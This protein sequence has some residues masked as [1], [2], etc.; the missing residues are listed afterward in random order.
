M[1]RFK[2]SLGIICLSMLSN[3]SMQKACADESPVLLPGVSVAGGF[4]D[5]NSGWTDAMVPFYDDPKQI[6]YLDPQGFYAGN[7]QYT[8][9]VG[10][11]FRLLTQRAGIIGAYVFGDYNHS[12]NN[13]SFWFISPGIERLGDTLDVSVN[14]YLPVNRQRFDTSTALASQTGDTQY[15]RFSGHDEFDQLLTFFESTGVGVDGEIGYRLPFLRNNTKIYVGGYYFA[16]QNTND[17]TGITARLE[18]P[19]GNHFSFSVSDAYDNVFNNTFKLGVSLSLFGR[20]THFYDHNVETRM[21]DPIQRNRIAVEGN[22]TTSQYIAQGQVNSGTEMLIADD[23]W[24]FSPDG[25]FVTIPT[26]ETCTEEMPC[27]NRNVNSSFFGGIN[28]IDPNAKMYLAPGDYNSIN[29]SLTLFNGQ[30]LWGRTEDYKLAAAGNNRALL[31]GSLDLFGNNLVDSVRLANNPSNTQ[32]QGIFF[33]EGATN[34]LINNVLIGNTGSDPTGAFQY[35]IQTDN[36]TSFTVL[37]SEIDSFVNTAV[38]DSAP[39][40]ISNSNHTITVSNSILSANRAGTTAVR[41]SGITDTGSNNQWTITGNQISA[42]NPASLVGNMAFGIFS[43]GGNN[44][45][46]QIKNNNINISANRASAGISSTGG[47]NNVWRISS[48]NIQTLTS[49]T[50]TA[51][52]IISTNGSNNNWRVSNNTITIIDGGVNSNGIQDNLGFQDIWRLQGNSISANIALG[53]GSLNGIQ[54]NGGTS[55]IWDLI[56]NT[57]NISVSGTNAFATG[58]F[59]R[60]NNGDIWN[61]TSNQLTIHGAGSGTDAYGLDVFTT[62]NGVWNLNNNTFSI[63]ANGAN[64][65]A[66]GIDDTFST[67]NTWN[68]NNNNINV[69]ISGTNSNVFGIEN[70]NGNG[71]TWSIINN[72]IQ[73]TDFGTGDAQGIF[74]FSGNTQTW[75][76]QDNTI[77]Q[78]TTGATAAAIG[79]SDSGNQS[80]QWNVV[81]NTLNS[82]TTQSSSAA[83]GIQSR[84]STLGTWGISGNNITTSTGQLSSPSLGIVLAGNNNTYTLSDNTINALSTGN[85]AAASAYGV[86][87]GGNLN[88]VTSTGDIITV[89]ATGTGASAYG[90]SANTT[91]AATST[92]TNSTISLTNDVINASSTQQSAYGLYDPLN[93]TNN[94]TWNYLGMGNTILV[95]APVQACVT[96]FQSGCT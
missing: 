21:V 95:S 84:S 79:I 17:I 77:T 55:N 34:N 93:T 70:L 57:I 68:L 11:G 64:A 66:Y 76:V 10:T 73:I 75:N 69:Q 9:S 56:N 81:N 39:I 62:Q 28:A 43:S 53:G 90:F 52:G 86:S 51:N 2:A 37:A 8:T 47:S 78:N 50:P 74:A 23:I 29:S 87:I 61:L 58:I 19:V 14:A 16:P 26:H 3:F 4:V 91:F 94:N 59:S 12:A 44:N 38:S 40:N 49:S 92:T 88:T 48:N 42:T 82:T 83:I 71:E 6:W 41:L 31:I 1:D 15:L 85:N 65:N 27:S 20:T 30:S 54:D 89:N 36:N 5:R 24:F 60:N 35:G 72:I 45:Y 67:N 22:A 13:N 33:E 63:L 96:L 80:T 7:N 46:W 32:L 18:V 25:T